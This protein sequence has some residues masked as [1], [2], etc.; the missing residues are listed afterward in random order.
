MVCSSGVE[1]S[2]MGPMVCPETSV[3]TYQSNVRNITETSVT[4]YQSKLRNI[5]EA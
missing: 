5:T 2:W 3:T 1:Q 4:T